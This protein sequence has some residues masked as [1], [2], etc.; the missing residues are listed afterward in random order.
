MTYTLYDWSLTLIHSTQQD[1]DRPARRAPTVDQTD[2][3]E[4]RRGTM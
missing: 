2:E 1:P 3:L 4:Q